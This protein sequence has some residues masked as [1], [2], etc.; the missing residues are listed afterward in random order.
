ME[1]PVLGAFA[2]GSLG[3]NEIAAGGTCKV[4]VLEAG[5]GEGDDL[6]LDR[7]GVVALEDDGAFG[8]GLLWVTWRPLSNGIEAVYGMQDMAE[9]LRRDPA[10][11]AL[12]F[13]LRRS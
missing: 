1:P 6:S 12:G 2:D 3:K 5:L 8:C 11:F 9:R 7:E 4:D 13:R 10:L